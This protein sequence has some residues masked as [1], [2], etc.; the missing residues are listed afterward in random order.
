MVKRRKYRKRKGGDRVLD[1]F[2]Y[3][4]ASVHGKH[5]QGC[6]GMSTLMKEIEA[7]QADMVCM[8]ALARGAYADTRAE[9]I[10]NSL[11][12]LKDYLGQRAKR[13]DMLCS[14]FLKMWRERGAAA[15]G[16]FR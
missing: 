16:P 2:P 15:G 3:G 9:H 5:E 13:L 7:V 4:H 10:G 8:E 1:R 6:G 14:H 12:V 11:E